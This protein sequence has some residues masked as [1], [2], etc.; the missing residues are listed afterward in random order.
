M[1]RPVH[2][3]CLKWGQRYG[4]EYVNILAAS[5]RRHL[6]RPYRF[7]CCTDD[8][9]GLAADIRVIPFPENPGIRRG[10]PD[11]LA[12]VVV[13]QDGFGGLEG[14]TLFL[15]LDVVV[16][17]SLD[18]LFDYKP[19]KPVMIHNWV[20]WHK[21]LLGLRPPAGNSSVFRFE[22]GASHY[23]F[24][25]LLAEGPRAEDRSVFNGDQEFLTY[26]FRELVWWPE[27]WVRSFKRHCRPVF[28]LN[29]WRQPRPPKH[30]RILV[31]H[32]RPDPP[33]AIGGW[34][35]RKLHRRTRPAPWI[36]DHWRP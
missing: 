5:V 34:R 22:A 18:E 27:P 1:S 19:G 32:G 3:L 29:L 33:E 35:D 16:M 2:V 23:V 17:G 21:A 28:P 24:E 9:T 10:W 8:P 13:T 31:F 26:A 36:A 14:P 4:P 11:I 6:R 25:K 12:K 7:H 20:G 30:C 15:D